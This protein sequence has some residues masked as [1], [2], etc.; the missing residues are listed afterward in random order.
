M[1]CSVRELFARFDSAE[2]ATWR[3]F[4]LIQPIGG[5]RGDWQAALV[6]NTVARCHGNKTKL[7]D[8]LLRFGPPGP[9]RKQ[10]P[11]EM[12]AVLQ[13]FAG[14]HNARFAGSLK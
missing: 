10:S 11:E 5:E 1:G 14:A 12:L 13:R 9:P 3:A 2:L 7:G 8:F 4:D 6:A